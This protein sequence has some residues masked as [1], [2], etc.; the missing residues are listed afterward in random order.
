MPNSPYPGLRAF[1]IDESEFF[2]GRN[3]LRDSLLERLHQS[4]FVAVIGP[5]GC[6]KSSLVKAGVM[7]TL[8][9]NPQW[10]MIHFRPGK[11][12]FTE[13]VR[14]LLSKSNLKIE[15][16]LSAD[17]KSLTGII[18]FVKSILE[19]KNQALSEILDE[20]CLTT[21]SSLLIYVDQL[22]EIF[23]YEKY[24]DQDETLGLISYLLSL[25]NQEE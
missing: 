19:G 3:R 9:N 1:E 15:N 7:A 4:R 10:R 23:R 8:E 13:F 5:S 20:I 16:L 2:F 21:F 14:S 25:A 17:E 6:G 22:D 11:R 24:C 12:P 18:P